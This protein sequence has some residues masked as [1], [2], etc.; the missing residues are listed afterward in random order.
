ME[1]Q[2][3]VSLN[4]IVLLQLLQQSACIPNLFFLASHPVNA[5]FCTMSST[6]DE[7]Y[8]ID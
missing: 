4:L 5:L 8:C 1:V 2:S 3:W 6:M 7:M